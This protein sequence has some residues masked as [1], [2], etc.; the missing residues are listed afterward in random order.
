[1]K[2]S[3][4]NFRYT[5]EMIDFLRETFKDKVLLDTTKAFNL[6]FKTDRSFM[7]I[8]EQL[9]DHKI[10]KSPEMR[11]KVKRENIKKA[12]EGRRSKTKKIHKELVKFMKKCAKQDMK[13]E[14]SRQQAIVKFEANISSS[15]FLRLSKENNIYFY[16][17]KIILPPFFD[18]PKV[19]DFIKKHEGKASWLIRDLLIE[20]FADEIDKS[21][22]NT[23][24]VFIKKYLKQNNIFFSD[25]KKQMK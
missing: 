24:V 11:L 7:G 20:K 3:K 14:E 15:M 2:K 19:K 21:K 23:S 16:T 9:H 25:I 8:R 18:K 10:Y 13:K 1:M 17:K 6:K 22:V 5:K 4:S 12:H